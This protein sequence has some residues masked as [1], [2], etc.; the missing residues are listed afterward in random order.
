MCHCQPSCWSQSHTPGFNQDSKERLWSILI[1]PYYLQTLWNPLQLQRCLLVPA[2][3]SSSATLRGVQINFRTRKNFNIKGPKASYIFHRGCNQYYTHV[4][5]YVV[6]NEP[7]V[8]IVI[9]HST[10][11]NKSSNVI[12]RLNRLIYVTPT[13]SNQDWTMKLNY[14]INI[15]TLCK[16]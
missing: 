4:N 10:N 16:N 15:Y 3:T 9:S 11:N 13:L 5:L 7:F 6:Y 14:P 8:F 2:S 1:I 12:K